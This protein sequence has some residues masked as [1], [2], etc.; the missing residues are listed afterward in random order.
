[1]ILERAVRTV[2]EQSA[3]TEDISSKRAVNAVLSGSI[4]SLK[5][6]GEDCFPAARSGEC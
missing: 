6:D 5:P 2:A 1:M 4:C 3:K